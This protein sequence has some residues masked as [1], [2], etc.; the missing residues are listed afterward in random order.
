MYS[1]RRL[2]GSADMQDG[3]GGLD[4]FGMRS[5]W[6]TLKTKIGDLQGLGARI[7][8]HWQKISVAQQTLLR[9]GKTREANM[10]GDELLKIADDMQKWSKVKQ[11]IDTYLPE[12]MK[13]DEGATPQPG[14]G[15]GAIPFILG[16]FALVALAYCVN[17]GLALLQDYAYKSQL[18]QAVIDQKI[19]SGQMAEIL[20]VPRN[21]GVLEKVISN[22]GLGVGVGI[23]STL[24]VG[25][26]L[27]LLYT[28]GVLNGIIKTVSSFLGSGS[29]SSSQSSM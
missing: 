10:M 19:S 3:L 29:S 17:T 20:S 7:S 14:S 24:L 9:H 28:T 22:V 11:Y 2:P 16:G 21:E 12:W 23:P 27:Y 15:V 8:Q 4:I 13:L 6:N 5:Y 26:G 25:G 18:T 1:Y